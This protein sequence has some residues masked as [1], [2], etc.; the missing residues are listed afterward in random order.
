MPFQEEGKWQDLLPG[1]STCTDVGTEARMRPRRFVMLAILVATV[2]GR[3]LLSPVKEL[4]TGK[5]V[6][7][8][9][10]IESARFAA[11][12][13]NVRQLRKDQNKEQ[14]KLDLLALAG[15]IDT[16][17]RHIADFNTALM[18]LVAHHCLAPPLVTPSV[19]QEG[20]A[21]HCQILVAVT[22]AN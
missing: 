2:F 13:Q 21:S 5:S 9:M 7:N 16:E 15:V 22:M 6:A 20:A 14:D 11:L 19:V 12:Q 18:G 1:G 10:E 3:F 17:A 8:P 4:F